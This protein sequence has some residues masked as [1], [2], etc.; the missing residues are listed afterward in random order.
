MSGD[1]DVE[2]LP[3]LP[4]RPPQ[5][6]TILWQGSPDWRRLAAAVFHIRAVA[7]YFG[8]LIIWQFA[9]A[10]HDGGALAD[11]LGQSA[12]L[13]AFA[14]ASIGLLSLLAF[15]M[16]RAAVYT[17]TNRRVV[18]RIGVALPITFNLPFARIE[19]A[20]LKILGDGVGDIALCLAPGERLA[21]LVLWPH[22][23]PWR[24][25]QP[26]PAL[27]CVKDARTV[28]ALMAQAFAQTNE[29]RTTTKLP[30]QR[31]VPARVLS[32]VAG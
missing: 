21:Y 1:F 26:R 5:G 10:W 4:E 27:R 19:G 29:S 12:M 13:L 2:P 32:P 7:L 20:D 14:L 22:A 28:A 11:A 16:A 6:E 8:A 23:R 9:A 3:G 31:D 30:Q 18:M 25:K 24:L 17:L 15:A